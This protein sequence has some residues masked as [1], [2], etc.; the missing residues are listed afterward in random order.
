MCLAVIETVIHQ[1]GFLMSRKG[2]G[3]FDRQGGIGFQEFWH[4]GEIG[5][6][7]DL[8]RCL[9]S[10]STRIDSSVLDPLRILNVQKLHSIYLIPFRGQMDI[11]GQTPRFDSDRHAGFLAVQTNFP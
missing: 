1:H 6:Q 11:R 9:G 8:L 3:Y 2:F 10:S 7:A 5:L 4:K